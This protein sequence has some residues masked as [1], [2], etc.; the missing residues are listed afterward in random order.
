MRSTAYEAITYGI[1]QTEIGK[2]IIAKTDKGLCWLGFMVEG[3]KG[4]GLQRMLK[5][6]PEAKFVQDDA[7]TSHLKDQ[8]LD[9]WHYDRMDII[10]LDLRGT[11]FQIDVW[12]ALRAIP[13][14]QVRTYGDIA[15]EVGRP[16]ASR[17]VGTAI[18]DNPV[19]LI[20]PCHRVIQQSG[21]IGNYGWG[22]NI[23]SN[24]LLEEN[25]VFAA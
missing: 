19:S 7:G 17:A 9:A 4:N 12:H 6:F 5:F 8:I 21:K 11:D 16:M 14:G 18:G 24:L 23:K 3:Y 20:V 15:K 13:K 22:T 2:I 10:P 25:V 1:H